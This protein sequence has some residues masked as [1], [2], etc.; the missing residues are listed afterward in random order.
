MQVVKHKE[1][2]EY[3]ESIDEHVICVDENS[4]IPGIR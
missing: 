4:L 2:C 3:L 1:F